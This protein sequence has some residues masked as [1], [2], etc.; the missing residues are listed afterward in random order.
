MPHA[1]HEARFVERLLVEDLSNVIREF[2][3]FE[4]GH[5][6]FDGVEHL[7]H[8]DVGSAVFG[9]FERAQGRRHRRIGVRSRGRDHVRRER[10]VIAAAVFGM[11]NEAKV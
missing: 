6:F 9:S 8:F 2:A 3:A 7:A 11:Q 1:V 4:I 10:G 5:V